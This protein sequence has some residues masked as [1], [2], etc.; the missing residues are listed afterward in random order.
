MQPIQNTTDRLVL[1]GASPLFR[2]FFVGGLGLFILGAILLIGGPLLGRPTIGPTADG[3]GGADTAGI[4]LFLTAF[5]FFVAVVPLIGRFPFRKELIV[6]R[7]SGQFIRRDRTLV[8]LREHTCPIDGI[9]AIEVDEARHV[10][11]DS[12]FTLLLRLD[13]GESL[14]LDR[15]TDRDAAD[16]AA[17]LLRGHLAPT[18][19]RADGTSGPSSG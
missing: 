11:G 15:F 19:P 9:R 4:G 7:P 14:T 3:E 5:G 10:D 8:R 18:A 1:R 17:R 6:D 13:S 2:P 16:A 12:Y